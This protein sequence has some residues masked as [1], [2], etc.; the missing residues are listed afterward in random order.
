VIL[1]EFLLAS[2]IKNDEQ[3]LANSSAAIP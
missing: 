2:V 1:S 3:M